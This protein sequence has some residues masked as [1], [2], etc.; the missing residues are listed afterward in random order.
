[1]KK[2]GFSQVVIFTSEKFSTQNL[3]SKYQNYF[4]GH[5]LRLSLQDFVFL[6]I[7]Q[8]NE[9]VVALVQPYDDFIGKSIKDIFEFMVAKLLVIPRKINL[10]F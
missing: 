4:V 3:R 8:G 7:V 1:M 2:T 5:K 9:V 10:L 6:F